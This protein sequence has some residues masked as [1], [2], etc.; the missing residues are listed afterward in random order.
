MVGALAMGAASVPQAQALPPAQN[1]GGGSGVESWVTDLN[2][3]QRLSRQ[4]TLR[5]Q[6]GATEAD[7][8]IVVDP[9]RRY[10]AM[11]GF[12]ASMTDSSAYVLSQLP[13]ARRKAIMAD[14]FSPAE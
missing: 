12:G 2:T 6:A 13:A 9:T 11:V 3:D 1:A 5:W 7:D 10:Q 14:L 8:G 4:P